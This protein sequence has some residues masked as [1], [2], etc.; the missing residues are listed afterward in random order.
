MP[1]KRILIV[2]DNA[3]LLTAMQ[4]VLTAAGYTVETACNGRQ[5]LEVIQQASPQLVIT[6]IQMPSMDGIALCYALRTS[7]QWAA[8][9]LIFISGRE[10][11][12]CC[13]PTGPVDFLLKPFAPED[14]LALVTHYV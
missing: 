13:E 5:A 9:P 11:K 8:I 1:K 6:D 10:N 12:N 4:D 3:V 2:E 7:D 14:L